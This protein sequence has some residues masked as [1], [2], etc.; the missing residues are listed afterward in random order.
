MP[1]SDHAAIAAVFSG[2]IRG[3]VYADGC[4]YADAESLNDWRQEHRLIDGTNECPEQLRG[5]VSEKAGL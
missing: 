4:V 1:L 5:I 3:S 2:R